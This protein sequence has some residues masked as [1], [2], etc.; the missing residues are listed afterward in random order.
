MAILTI[1]P[2]PVKY[3]KIK[4]TAMKTLNV[5]LGGIMML[6]GVLI[7]YIAS[8]M[9]IHAFRGISGMIQ[10]ALVIA[11]GGVFLYFGYKRARKE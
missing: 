8:Q 1:Q 6:L 2:P 9:I 11:I 7:L 5:I 4:S 3:M 10:G